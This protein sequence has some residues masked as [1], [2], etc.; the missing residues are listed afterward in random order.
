VVGPEDPLAE[1]VVDYFSAAGTAIFGPTQAAAQIEASK[2]FSKGLFQKYGIPC[3]KSRTFSDLNQAKDYVNQ[4]QAP[5]VVKADGLAAGKG[6]IMAETT[7]EALEAVSA[8]MQDKAFGGAGNQVVIEEKLTGKEM[9]FFAVTDGKSILPLVPACDYKRAN[10]GDQG[11]N[12]GGMGSYSPPYFY[13]RELGKKAMETIIEPT[14]KALAKEDRLYQGVLYAGLML[15]SK[16]NQPKIL[17][18]N[19]RFGDP[20]CQVIM[21]RLKSDLL[22][23]IMG[24]VNGNLETVIPEWSEEACVGVT[25]AS[26][27][28]PV[29]YRTGLPISGLNTLDKDIIIFHAGTKAG[30]KAGEVLTN[31]GRVL[32]IVATGKT[33]DEAR[34]KIYANVPRI[35][36][37]GCH[38]RR[39]IAL[40]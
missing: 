13:S 40:F 17:E 31:G 37:E 10:D 29:K 30:D 2:A 33:T 11:L 21:P 3:A 26:G 20:E 25:L 5:L 28:Y 39:D 4:Q 24:V 27:G 19:A 34:E 9:S 22:D 35:Q 8:I 32:T 38:Y 15:D 7:A 14:V 1:G 16:S 18:Y 12:T 23:M 6:V 36:F